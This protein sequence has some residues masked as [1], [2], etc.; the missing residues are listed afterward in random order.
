MK[1]RLNTK[2]AALLASS[3][4]PY[5]DGEEWEVCRV[6]NNRNTYILDAYN[7][8][9][10]VKALF[11][12]LPIEVECSDDTDPYSVMESALLSI[13]EYVEENA[14]DN[15]QSRINVCFSDIGVFLSE[16]AAKESGA[17]TWMWHEA[18]F[19]LHN[20]FL[21]FDRAYYESNWERIFRK[22][23]VGMWN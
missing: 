6:S 13:R 5:W 9:S 8:N 3:T 21:L 23:I 16:E 1:K 18:V 20:P 4:I 11:D 15:I 7:E 10:D 12:T 2:S 17:T 19:Q 22:I 14:C